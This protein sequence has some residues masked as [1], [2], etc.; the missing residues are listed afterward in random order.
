MGIWH[1]IKWLVIIGL[2]M[3]AGLIG[4]FLIW[5]LLGYLADQYN[6]MTWQ[7]SVKMAAS[8]FTLFLVAIFWSIGKA[9]NKH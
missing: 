5:C 9:S 7:D 1:G 3:V 4:L 2:C 6:Q 8:L